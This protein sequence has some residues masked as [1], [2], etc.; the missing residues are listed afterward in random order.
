MGER[1]N[2]L[3][4]RIRSRGD[5]VWGRRGRRG[6]PNSAFQIGSVDSGQ[7]GSVNSERTVW[8]RGSAWEW[9]E[10]RL[11]PSQPAHPKMRDEQNRWKR[12]L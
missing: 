10:R 3:L 11:R 4:M 2:L 6:N 8:R 1:M 7:R 9:G 5:G 12:I